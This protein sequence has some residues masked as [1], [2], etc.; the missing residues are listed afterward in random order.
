MTGRWGRAEGC[1][2]PFFFFHFSSRMSV[3][4]PIKRG[5]GRPPKGGHLLALPVVAEALRWDA[6]ELERLLDCVPGTL[7]G[8][9]RRADGWWVPEGALRAVLAAPAGLLPQF[10]TVAEVAESLRVSKS[11]VYQWTRLRGVDGRPV[12]ESRQV[13]GRVLIPVAAVLRLPARMPEGAAPS[14]FSA[15]H[16]H[17][18]AGGADD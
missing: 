3:S 18:N 7:P 10:A 12:L 13:L 15:E 9:V 14:F 5:R 11:A 6:L 8:A 2:G 1:P 16:P 4:P 17:S